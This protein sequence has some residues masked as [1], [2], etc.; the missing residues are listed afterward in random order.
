VHRRHG[1]AWLELA[2]ACEFFRKQS[3]ERADRL[4][5]ATLDL[6]RVVAELGSSLRATRIELNKSRHFTYKIKSTT[7]NLERAVA[8]LSSSLRT[9]QNLL[10]ESMR[11]LILC[12]ESKFHVAD[13]TPT[14]ELPSKTLSEA[15]QAAAAELSGQNPCSIQLLR[16]ASEIDR[17]LTPRESRGRVLTEGTFWV[18]LS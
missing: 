6:E 15:L 16:K 8:E 12:N 5:A 2:I 17:R 9:N 10:N 11:Q 3:L 18:V 13:A 7:L 4:K 14:R 1:S